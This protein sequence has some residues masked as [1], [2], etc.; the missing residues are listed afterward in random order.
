MILQMSRLRILGPR[1]LLPDVF[2]AL[3]DIGSLQLDPTVAS[4]PYL[5]PS[6]PTAA[7]VREIRYL[8]AA[9]D[10]IET[11]LG[12]LP[13]P[14]GNRSPGAASLERRD[15]ARWAR[16][17]RRARRSLGALAGEK[18]AL[19][20]ERDYLLKYRD[21]FTVFQSLFER[22]PRSPDASEHCLVLRDATEGTVGRLR[23]ALRSLAGPV[24]E[25]RSQE[26]AVGELAILLRFRE[27]SPPGLEKIFADAGVQEVTVPPGYAEPSLAQAIPRM[28]QRLEGIGPQLDRLDGEILALCREHGRELARGRYYL[29]DRLDRLEAFPLP[30]LTAHAF[31]IE[32]WLPADDLP[33]LTR[34]LTGQFPD[35]L[36]AEELSREQWTGAEAP[37]VLSNP[38]L[39][40]PFEAL[41]R[42]LPLPRYGSL[43]PTPFVAVFF[44]MFFGLILGDVG[45]GVLLA[46]LASIVRW[47]SGPGGLPRAVSEMAGACAAFSILFGFLYGELFG[48]LGRR[49]LG[50]IPLWFDRREALLPFLGLAVSMGFVHILLGLVLGVAAG[51]RG[52]ARHAVGRGVEAIMIVLILLALL[53]AVEVLPGAFFTPAVVALVVAFPILVIAE[54]LLAPIELLA[55]VG[56]IFSYARIMALGTASVMMAVVANRMIGAMGSLL[57]GL[58]FALLFHLVN[59][60]L[61]LFGPTIHALRLHYVEFFGKFYSPGGAPYRPLR[62]WSPGARAAGE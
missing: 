27:A 46:V 37:V 40:R 24:F 7:H 13:S 26:L 50:Q 54:G 62:H 38:R 53:A 18:A 39:F 23:D 32:G 45:Y 21:I 51:L 29:H 41:V 16:L 59:F 8:R 11:V 56:N 33:R 9:I 4:R 14:P 31:V 3:Q 44:P 52:R 19:R 28:L 60:A 57:V 10:D 61:G 47:R 12:M 42:F 55:A 22:E 36:V 48:D 43:D 6:V 20:E 25:L 5:Q 17:A 1:E 35:T 34:R 49:L 15:V 2:V 30:G 58:L